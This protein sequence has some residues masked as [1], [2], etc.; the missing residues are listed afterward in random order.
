MLTLDVKYDESKKENVSSFVNGNH[1]LPVPKS[2]RVRSGTGLQPTSKRKSEKQRKKAMTKHYLKCLPVPN[3]LS[4]VL[5]VTNN[6][7]SVYQP[8]T[9]G[10]C[11]VCF[12]DSSF[13]NVECV[14]VNPSCRRTD[15]KLHMVHP[16]CLLRMV[17]KP[18]YS[19]EVCI[20]CKNP[21]IH[22][23][24]EY[25]DLLKSFHKHNST[26]INMIQT[27]EETTEKC[28]HYR[29]SRKS[30][31]K[32][33]KSDLD[34]KEVVLA[35]LERKL[36][37]MITDEGNVRERERLVCVR[38]VQQ[39]TLEKNLQPRLLSVQT[40]EDL[41]SIKENNASK[42]ASDGT[43]ALEKA[44]SV[45]SQAQEKLV[46]AVAIKR[47]YTKVLEAQEVQLKRLKRGAPTL[48]TPGVLGCRKKGHCL[49]CGYNWIN[50]ITCGVCD[51]LYLSGDNQDV[52]GVRSDGLLIVIR[53]AGVKISLE[54]VKQMD[55]QL[56]QLL[57]SKLY[58]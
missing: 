34:N 19:S 28:K 33:S 39:K 17:Q 13:K 30:I 8:I 24:P 23:P 15:K 9:T 11:I 3:E 2:Q 55:K 32:K 46:E 7:S 36:S 53:K 27:L 16:S 40:R 48:G 49:F 18:T 4:T 1:L 26:C 57:W 35:E 5:T 22:E 21:D 45:E 14:T 56:Q 47:K 42:T 37:A 38:E 20:A 43:L 6:T 44:F 41:I 54:Q 31:L 58:M 10:R 25:L 52:D 29:K 12:G 51:S 50:T